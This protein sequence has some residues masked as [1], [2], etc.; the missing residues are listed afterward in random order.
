[1]FSTAFFRSVQMKH[2]RAWSNGSGDLKGNAKISALD[3]TAD[4]VRGRGGENDGTR[5]REERAGAEMAV[6]KI[7]PGVRVVP[8]RTPTLP[9]ATHTNCV[10]LG[11]THL[12]VVDPGSPDPTEQRRL[13]QV[14]DRLEAEGRCLAAVLLTHHH[15]DHVGGAEYLAASRGLPLRA[16]ADCARHLG[17]AITEPIVTGSDVA[18]DAN[19][20]LQAILTS[21]HAPGHLV[22]HDRVNHALV[23]GD[24][25]ASTGTIM[26]DPEHG[27][28]AAYLDSLHRLEMLQARFLLP[29]HGGRIDA[30]GAV[31]RRYIRHRREREAQ[32]LKVIED[33]GAISEPQLLATVYSDVPEALRYSAGRSL[34]A[35]LIKLVDEGRVVRGSGPRHFRVAHGSWCGSIDEGDSC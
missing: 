16:H 15:P 31:L 33:G 18:A 4:R 1:L 35:H 28:M 23:A 22:F 27:D 32:I 25:V 13:D 9:P 12:V 7:A 14:L 19:Y 5:G 2:R 21:G 6:I 29:A 8:L 26:I 30:A 20:P 24:M 17:F 34:R 3:R 10:L 11:E